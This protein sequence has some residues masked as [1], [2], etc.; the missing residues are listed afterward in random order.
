M[1]NSYQEKIKPVKESFSIINEMSNYDLIVFLQ[2]Q[3]NRKENEIK[4]G[5]LR[6]MD[7]AFE[8]LRS[9]CQETVDAVKNKNFAL[10]RDG[11]GDQIT[12][13]HYLAFV[14]EDLVNEEVVTLPLE[15]R[16][17]TYTDYINRVK[18][19]LDALDL[20]LV[21]HKN[22]LEIGTELVA[23]KASK[24]EKQKAFREYMT[25]LHS[26]PPSSKIDIRHDL[27]EIT[28]SSLSK[29]CLTEEIAQQTLE[30]YQSKGYKVHIA[31]SESGWVILSSADHYVGEDFIPSNK[32]LKSINWLECVFDEIDEKPQW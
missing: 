30:K 28:F 15:K 7:S 3:F 13:A 23:S 1:S 14:V 19:K 11:V 10:L 25:E 26:L 29:I 16:A 9:E 20:V 6:K 5:D 8:L 21:G 22:Q 2:K 24:E 32:F 4:S 12:V 27:L 17:V 18:A 31:K